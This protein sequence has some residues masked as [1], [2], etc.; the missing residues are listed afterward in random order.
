M[1]VVIDFEAIYG[2]DDAGRVLTSEMDGRFVV[3][4]PGTFTA[5]GGLPTPV[6]CD[7]LMEAF[8]IP[9]ARE[10]TLIKILVMT[11][12]EEIQ[13]E[14]EK[15]G[16]MADA[17]VPAP[18]E[19]EEMP[20]DT[21]PLDVPL[22][23]GNTVA[24]DNMPVEKSAQGASGYGDGASI[25]LQSSQAV[26]APM[27]RKEPRTVERTVQNGSKM[28]A[29]SLSDKAATAFKLSDLPAPS[30]SA[31]LISPNGTTTP[32]DASLM[33]GMRSAPNASMPETASAAYGG[34]RSRFMQQSGDSGP[35]PSSSEG[36]EYQLENSAEGE[37]FVSVKSVSFANCA[38]LI[39]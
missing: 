28:T 19:L 38:P 9:K 26:E 5:T 12:D 20:S 24:E 6:L 10:S 22:V 39:V 13:E 23:F 21:D 1:Y 11:D 31:R 32:H 33:N 17:P 15:K 27:K 4:I 30:M 34:K 29:T 18:S 3:Y 14:L 16:L 2:R 8:K 36:D 35:R 7:W 25:S 37:N